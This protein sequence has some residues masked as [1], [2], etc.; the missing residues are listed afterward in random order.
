MD[1]SRDV[2]DERGLVLRV[3]FLLFLILS[4]A[5]LIVPGP[6]HAATALNQLCGAAGYGAGCIG[7]F[8]MSPTP[9]MVAPSGGGMFGG[10][11]GAIVGAVLMDTL[12]S[13]L[14]QA[15]A[16][17]QAVREVS[18]D[19]GRVQA[20]QQALQKQ[21]R[22]Q[23]ERESKLL[24]QLLDRPASQ[25]IGGTLGMGILDAVRAEA[26]SPFD[27]NDPHST[28][29]ILYDAW[30]SPEPAGGIWS[31]C[32][33]VPTGDG[34]V[35]PSLRPVDCMGKLCAFPPGSA[36][37]SI[38]KTAPTGSGSQPG[39]SGSSSRRTPNVATEWRQAGNQVVWAARWEWTEALDARHLEILAQILN[40]GGINW[41]QQAL[42]NRTQQEI[43][44]EGRNIYQRVVEELIAEIFGVISDAVSGRYQEALERSD[45]IG[46]RVSESILPH[47]K[48]SRLLISGEG[49]EV[50]QAAGEIFWEHAKEVAKEVGK[51]A[52]DVLPGPDLVKEEARQLVDAVDHWLQLIQAK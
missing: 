22:L 25:I 31:G 30:F 18:V 33:P 6:A 27:G 43:A 15:P 24:S 1:G 19:P 44:R 20:L 5:G 41:A 9:R 42:L 3:I 13:G 12:M 26:G 34:A 45:T 50:G 37:V 39:L 46:D 47:L 16:Q 49:E 2:S 7:A 32:N 52:L 29:T 23:Q 10:M 21:Q 35:A 51:D 48:M 38:V 14:D 11:M 8:R 17:T 28:W 40:S 4:L 36:R